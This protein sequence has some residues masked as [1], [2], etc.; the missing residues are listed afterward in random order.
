LPFYV[1]TRIAATRGNIAGIGWTIGWNILGP[2]VTN[3][4]IYNRAFFGKGS[5]IYQE[6]ERKN[7]WNESKIFKD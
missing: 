1:G 7:D 5:S 4:E 2:W 3:S 6:R